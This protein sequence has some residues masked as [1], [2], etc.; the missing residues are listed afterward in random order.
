MPILDKDTVSNKLL[1]EILPENLN[2]TLQNY[3]DENHSD[4]HRVEPLDDAL[5]SCRHDLKLTWLTKTETFKELLRDVDVEMISKEFVR[6]E[7][8]AD[9]GNVARKRNFALSVRD[10]GAPS[11]KQLNNG[12]RPKPH[13]ILEKTIKASSLRQA[14]GQFEGNRI[15]EEIRKQAVDIEGL[16][17][18]WGDPGP[19]GERTLLGIQ[20]VAADSIKDTNGTALCRKLTRQTEGDQFY[21][22]IDTND[23]GRSL[24]PLQDGR[25]SN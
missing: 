6:R 2:Q 13:S 1:R 3:H 23:L 4:Y 25:N 24:Q 9:I 19:L 17:G 20:V 8:M 18:H 10:S 14:Y 15:L 21:L 7:D 12:T 22:P 16:V 5:Q 11:L